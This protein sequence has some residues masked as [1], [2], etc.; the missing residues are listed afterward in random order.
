MQVNLFLYDDFETMDA[1]SLAEIFG[2]APDIFH[3]NYLSLLGD[4]VNSSHGTKIWTEHLVPEET[5]G[6]IVIPGGK[7]SRRLIQQPEVLKAL[8]QAVDRASFCLSVGSG[9]VLLAKTGLLFHR[10]VVLRKPEK[11]WSRWVSSGVNWISDRKWIDDGKYYSA[12]DV[13]GNIDMA[14]DFIASQFDMDL[15]NRIA[16]H[17]G[18]QWDPSKNGEFK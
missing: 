6:I 5:S 18:Y 15:A 1:L 4:I 8:R 12:S 16:E 9:S 7:G 2:F 14:I 10:N 17:I 3:V 13:L 11:N